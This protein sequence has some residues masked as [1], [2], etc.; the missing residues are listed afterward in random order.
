MYI[1][2]L[3]DLLIPAIAKS[4]RKNASFD[5][6]HEV[7]DLFDLECHYECKLTCAINEII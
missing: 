2:F 5:N 6:D 4:S 1:Q 7:Q 3:P